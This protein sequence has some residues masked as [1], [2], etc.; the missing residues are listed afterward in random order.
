MCT[1]GPESGHKKICEWAN[2]GA[3][4]RAGLNVNQYRWVLD[5][6]GA[7]GGETYEPQASIRGTKV[8]LISHEHK[9]NK[10]YKPKGF[11]GKLLSDAST[12]R[13]RDIIVIHV[14]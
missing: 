6:T 13:C 5:Y 12:N 7:T 8:N 11:I 1:S 4:R 14:Q 3:W 9:Q 10:G 2:G